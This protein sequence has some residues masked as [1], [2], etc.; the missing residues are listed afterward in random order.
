MIITSCGEYFCNYQSSFEDTI[1][2]VGYQVNGLHIDNAL[3]EMA[4]VKIK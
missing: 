3:D 2:D 1:Y 4:S